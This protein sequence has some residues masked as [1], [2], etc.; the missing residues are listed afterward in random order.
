[1]DPKLLEYFLR[2]AEIGS[3]NR[4]ASELRLSQPSLSRWLSILEREVGTPLL[5]RSRQGIRL[6]DA[7]AVLA[8]RSGRILREMQILREEIGRKAVTQVALAMPSSMQRLVT[9]PFAQQIVSEQPHIRLRVYEGINNAVRR[10]MEQ[11]QVDVAMMVSTEQPP[12][13][14]STIPFVSEQLMLVGNRAARLRLDKPIPLA[15]LGATDLILPGRPNVIRAH[16]EHALRRAGRDLQSR[17]EA[18]TLSLCLELTRRG[19][20]FTIMPFC[21]L[22]GSQA[23]KDLSLAPISNLRIIWCLHVNRARAHSTNVHAVAEALR[24]FLAAQITSGAW[25]LAELIRRS[26]PRR[27]HVRSKAP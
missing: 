1:V 10:W 24:A 23:S 19:L 2:V 18:E 8:E 9:A 25:R 6:S 13:S 26:P 17:L 27:G 7:G 16:V 4:A 11:G 22:Q 5:I 21:A 12:D 3:I 20:G 14:F 15:R